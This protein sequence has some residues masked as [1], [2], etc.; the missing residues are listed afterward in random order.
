MT[1]N[2][3]GGFPPP[4]NSGGSQR[5]D[6]SEFLVLILPRGFSASIL[7]YFNFYGLISERV[8]LENIY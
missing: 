3:L 7:F 2:F 8:G 1:L 6:S 4:R 5:S